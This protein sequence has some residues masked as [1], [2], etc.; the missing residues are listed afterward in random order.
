MDKTIEIAK[1]TLADYF[2]IN[3]DEFDTGRCRKRNIIEAKRFLIY[4]IVNELSVKFLYVSDHIRSL[5]SHATAMHHYYKMIDL[6]ETEKATKEKYDNFKK[7]MLSK[8]M[9]KLEAELCRQIDVRNALNKNIKQLE[10]MID[11]A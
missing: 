11:E 5:K 2:N 3:K 10:K 7:L 9:N 6:M 8:G 4:F 1:V